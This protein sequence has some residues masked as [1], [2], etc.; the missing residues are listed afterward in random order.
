MG[1]RNAIVTFL[2]FALACGC[3][4]ALA[5]LIAN[6]EQTHQPTSSP[7]NEGDPIVDIWIN[8]W[9]GFF[10]VFLPNNTVRM[11]ESY[12]FDLDS[13]GKWER[14]QDRPIYPESPKISLPSYKA[15]FDNG[16]VIEIFLYTIFHHRSIVVED[17]IIGHCG[18]NRLSDVDDPSGF[19]RKKFSQGLPE[20]LSMIN[21]YWASHRGRTIESLKSKT[22]K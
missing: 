12:S 22:A 10:F 9:E 5:V 16:R 20:E 8:R 6:I 1:F 17:K 3:C 2:A 18:Y 21:K 19:Y 15:E 11:Y 13:T 14:V 7:P 4:V